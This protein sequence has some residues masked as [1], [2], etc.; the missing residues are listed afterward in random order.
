[1]MTRN[2]RRYEIVKKLL[3]ALLAIVLILQAGMFAAAAESTEKDKLIVT[4]S[5][6]TTDVLAALPEAGTRKSAQLT[7]GDFVLS[8]E[9]IAV[10]DG[11]YS[12]QFRLRPNG[13]LVFD[14][15]LTRTYQGVSGRYQLHYAIDEADR[16]TMIVNGNF[17]HIITA[18]PLL[19]KLSA[20]NKSLI[21]SNVS[22]DSYLY[23]LVLKTEEKLTFKNKLSFLYGSDQHGFTV[24][25]KYDIP[26][27]KQTLKIS[28]TDATKQVIH[29][30]LDN[31]AEYVKT[32]LP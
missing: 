14:N 21:R 20:E 22:E 25:Y 16:H 12:Y 18:S 15:D 4:L 1:M 7:S 31:A 8:G 32:L 23:K 28:P 9:N 11:V 24:Y 6:L 2:V 19:E 5:K 17:E 29:T 10:E 26:K 27:D 30:A 3:S 13:T